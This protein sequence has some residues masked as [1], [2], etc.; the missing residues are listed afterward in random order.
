MKIMILERVE[1]YLLD[2]DTIGQKRT[3]DLL[4]IGDMLGEEN[5][6]IIHIGHGAVD[7]NKDMVKQI[8]AE[9]SSKEFQILP[10][11]SRLLHALKNGL[12][13]NLTILG[14]DAF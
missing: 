5:K 6:K 11:G 7:T 2:I 13:K 1:D 12:K 14:A 10:T 4:R 9:R 3:E 8:F